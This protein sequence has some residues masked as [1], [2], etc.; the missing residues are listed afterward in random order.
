MHRLYIDKNEN[1]KNYI[2]NIKNLNGINTLFVDEITKED[3]DW[4]KTFSIR[5]AV[6][7]TEN[8]DRVRMFNFE[9]L[10]IPVKV[11]KNDIKDGFIEIDNP[12]KD[13]DDMSI[14][15]TDGESG[16]NPNLAFESD[17]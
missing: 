4:L 15:A 9:K 2:K 16:K 14:E 17:K 3:F 12:L 8:E 7:A 5:G 10:E 1:L 13:W 11:K 6:N